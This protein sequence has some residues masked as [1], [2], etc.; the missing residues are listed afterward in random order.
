MTKGLRIR[1]DRTLCD[2]FG[3]CA[4]HAPDYFSLDDWGYASL[5][6][7]GTVP[8]KDRDAVM[9]AL[10]DCPV[11]AIIYMGEHRPSEDGVPHVEAHEAPEPDPNSDGNEAVWGFVR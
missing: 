7:D 11:H 3:V 5:V 2:G 6:G 9:R 1:L 4:K 10:M 8:E